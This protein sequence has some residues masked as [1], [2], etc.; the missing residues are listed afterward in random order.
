MA[1]GF[2]GGCVAT[3]FNAPFDVA[4]SRI[5]SQRLDAG[6]PKYT[7]TVQTL[8]LVVRCGPASPMR[9]ACR[10]RDVHAR[11]VPPSWPYLGVIE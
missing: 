2:V 3:S 4:K 7:A 6:V 5:Q 9:A 1:V 10:A 8:S 11:W